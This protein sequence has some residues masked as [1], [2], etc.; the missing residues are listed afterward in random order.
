MSINVEG[1]ATVMAGSLYGLAAI[2][3]NNPTGG[4]ISIT[5]GSGDVIRSGGTGINA[6]VAASS[7]PAT[8]TI[9]ITTQQGTITS[10]YNF[11][12]GGG[13]PSG[14][15]AGYSF[16][17]SVNPAVH[18]NVVLDI[19]A[20]VNA[21]SGSGINLYNFGVGN[22]SATIEASSTISAVSAGVN[23]F[24]QGGG[25]VSIANLGSISAY[26]GSGITVGTGGNA[27]TG[28]GVISI[29]N[30]NGIIGLGVQSNAVVQI[31]NNSTQ[32]ATVTNSGTISSR[33]FPSS[34]L[35]FAVA[36]NNG[37]N[38][39]NNGATTVTN[40]GTGVIF[41]NVLL[42]TSP[43]ATTATTFTNQAGGF[44]AVNGSSSFNGNINSIS[45]SGIIAVSGYSAFYG[46]VG[47]TFTLNN[48]ITGTVNVGPNSSLYVGAA[49][50]GSGTFT[51]GDGSALEF[52]GTVAAGQT[53]SF[54][55]GDNGVLR[56]DDPSNF[57]GTIS[58]LAT[59]DIIHLWRTQYY[60][61]EHRRLDADDYQ[62]RRR[63]T[64]LSGCWR[65]AGTPFNVLVTGQDRCGAHA[66][67]TITGQS[68]PYVD[69]P[70]SSSKTY[71]FANDAIVSP[72]ARPAS[73]LAHRRTAIRPTLFSSISIRLR[74]FQCRLRCQALQTASD[75]DWR[76]QHRP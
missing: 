23:A 32:G 18:G 48:S 31:N 26:A 30:S 22:L 66:A 42:G 43:S 17:G 54:A 60:K 19:S 29:N 68:T 57:Q 41:G 59:G 75:H 33:L 62:I 9:T 21:V 3:A 24:A 53:V 65:S 63:D 8:S 51:I 45:N 13:T 72:I 50:T 4:N 76:R 5:T 11:F 56:L 52:V 44:W 40:T 14:I 12:Q 10:G 38:S 36:T 67:V 1:N 69:G 2:T 16:N 58:G 20:T 64:D 71:I 47:S 39:T 61:R 25:N 35:N 55:G 28:N 70:L 6:N 15:S 73:I 37:T 7:T 74:R 49:V 27:S 46:A 34:S